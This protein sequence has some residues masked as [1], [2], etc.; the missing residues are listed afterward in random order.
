MTIYNAHGRG[1]RGDVCHV[2]GEDDDDDG[3]RTTTTTTTT[4]DDD[5]GRRTMTTDRAILWP[6]NV[7]MIP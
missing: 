3:R 6:A 4:T 5:D 7:L 2:T 1:G